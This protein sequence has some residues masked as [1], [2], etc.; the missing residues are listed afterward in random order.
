MGGQLIDGKWK[1]EDSFADENGSYNRQETSFRDWIGND[2]DD[3]RVDKKKYPAEANRYHLYVSYACP[4]AHRTLILRHL[5]E[6]DNIIDVSVVHPYML[7][8]GW[9]FR[10]DFAGSTGDKLYNFDYLR[11][12]YIKAKSNYTGKVTV[13]VLWDKKTETIVNNESADIIRIFNTAFN[14][15]TGNKDDFYPQTLREDINKIND[16]IYKTVNN[17]VYKAGFAEQQD[18]YEKNIK[19]LFETL[20]WLEDRLKE[21]GPYLMGDTLTEAD[22][23]LFTTLIRFDAVYYGHFKCNIKQIMDYP[24]LHDYTLRLYKMDEINST[25]YFDHIKNHYYYSHN[26][27]NPHRVVPVGPENLFRYEEG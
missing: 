12:L 11:E 5:K 4:W 9:S 3:T 20:D 10:S 25:V 1:T 23:R 8:E 6:L 18:V 16:R 19:P 2:T 13:P 22:I 15:L 24:A 27:I 14:D 17:G 26:T 7:D 21:N